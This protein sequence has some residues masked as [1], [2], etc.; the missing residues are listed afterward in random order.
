MAELLGRQNNVGF[1]Y[2]GDRLKHCRRALHNVLNSNVISHYWGRLMDEESVHLNHRFYLSPG[3]FYEDTQRFVSRYSCV[4]G[5]PGVIHIPSV[6]Q[7]FVVR[8]T[9][10][11][12]PTLEF[13]ELAKMV[14]KETSIALQPG[15]WLVNTFPARM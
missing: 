6:I 8:L 5:D 9:Y 10:G 15:R 1:Q 4:A 12:N 14:Q 2:Y 13:I 7:E 3:S 11:Q